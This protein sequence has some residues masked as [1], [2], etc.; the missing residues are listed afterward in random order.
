M[1]RKAVVLWSGGVDSTVCLYLYLNKPEYE[2]HGMYVDYGHLANACELEYV[3][4]QTLHIRKHNLDLSERFAGFEVAQCS[5]PSHP[6]TGGSPSKYGE[7]YL[8]SMLPGRNSV[9][10]MMGYYMARRIGADSVVLGINASASMVGYKSSPDTTPAWATLMQAL[11]NNENE[12]CGESEPRVM[13]RTPLVEIQ[14][15][16]ILKMAE[17]MKAP[18]FY[19]WGCFYPVKQSGKYLPCG[20]CA[21][22]LRRQ[23]VGLDR[24]PPGS[25]PESIPETPVPEARMA[26]GPAEGQPPV[27]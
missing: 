16:E 13:L 26:P 14:K 4:K 23:A 24:P 11:F 1:T 22:C 17:E 8:S 15:P 10:A 18:M 20:K 6:L 25:T 7:G 5:F 2:V 9:F 3:R 21:G 12:A 27:G 19:T